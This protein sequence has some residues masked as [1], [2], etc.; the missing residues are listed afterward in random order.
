MK[1]N[2]N[3][4]FD[5][6]QYQAVPLPEDIM[7]M[8][9]AGNFDM[10]RAMIEN[11]LSLPNLP[12]AYRA[13]LNLELK[14]LSHLEKNYTLS[15]AELLEKIQARIPDFTAEELDQFILEGRFEWIFRD[16][17]MIFLSSTVSNLFRQYAD[18]W[19]RTPEGDP[20]ARDFDNIESVLDGLKDGD[21]MK[22]HIHI[23]HDLWL[24]PEVI[25]PGKTIHVHMPLPL[26]RAQIH[27]LKVLNVSPQP[28]HLPEEGDIMPTAYFEEK[29][30]EGQVFSVEYEFDNILKYVDMSKVD[31]EAI[32]QAGFP[33]EVMVYTQEKAPH[34]VFTPYL[35]ALAA[36]IKGDE[37]NPVKIAR[38][39]Y[40]Y[41][42]KNLRYTY[43]RDYA[44]MDIIS[45]RMALGRRGDCGVQALLFITLCRICGIPARWQS[46]LDSEP[47]SIGSHDWT[48]FY[49]PTL[50]WRWA[51]TSFGL[52][53][54]MRKHEA[55]WNFFFGNLDPFR[56]PTN[57]DVMAPFNPPMQFIRKDPCDSQG[58]EV[59]Y[60]DGALICGVHYEFTDLGIKLI[61]QED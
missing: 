37:T 56:I 6:L 1:T 40:D 32:E 14:T 26:E 10:V 55:R 27:N 59:E 35:K 25:E 12:H 45:E 33:E 2:C 52:A 5:D 8:K 23:R 31:F 54:Y 53:A 46:G 49:V 22:A 16:G 7:K 24:D 4:D 51:D 48:Q 17:E 28:K 61:K 21:E 11:R 47:G 29:A 13:R 44:S 15:K 20:R 3:I 43:V 18:V 60:D 58:G 9:W 50:G 19:E 39:I 57:C 41:I 38:R 34:I 30:A 36:E 42:T